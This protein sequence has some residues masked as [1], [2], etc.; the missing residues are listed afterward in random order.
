MKLCLFAFFLETW[1][2]FWTEN[3]AKEWC[4]LLD[5]VVEVYVVEEL[6]KSSITN[7]CVRL[8][9]THLEINYYWMLIYFLKKNYHPSNVSLP[10]IQ[11]DKN[12]YVAG[13]NLTWPLTSLKIDT[14]ILLTQ[15]KALSFQK[16]NE[17]LFS[18][19]LCFLPKRSLFQQIAS[20][21]IF[22]NWILKWNCRIENP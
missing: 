1:I 2:L 19:S 3:K 8:L 15:I 12:L 6:I 11:L 13:E 14:C 20:V 9:L 21:K 22:I 7:I 18:S 4:Y 17:W 10:S 5:D 16:L